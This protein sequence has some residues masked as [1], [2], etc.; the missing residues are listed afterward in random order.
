MPQ[1]TRSRGH[2]MTIPA[3]L[4]ALLNQ[5]KVLLFLGAGCSLEAPSRLPSAKT[6]AA[7][8][9]ADGHG[10]PGQELE[11]IAEAMYAST[12]GWQAFVNALP[13]HEWRVTPCN[14]AHAVISEL[15]K[16][17]LIAQIV[18]T[19]WDLLM[20]SSLRDH[21][22]AYAPI[23]TASSLGVEPANIPRVIKLHGDIDHPEKIRARRSELQAPEWAADWAAALFQTLVRTHSV[24]YIGYSGSSQ[25]VTLTV[26]K[27]VGSGE[28]DM[29]DYLVDVRSPSQLRSDAAAATFVGALRV[30]DARIVESQAGEFCRELRRAIYPLLLERPIRKSNALLVDLTRDTH[31]ILPELQNALNGIQ[32]SWKLAGPIDA[33]MWLL[34]SFGAFPELTVATPYVSIVANATTLASMWV[35]L[36]LVAWADPAESRVGLVIQT[37]APENLGG[38]I[39]W[40]VYPC[41]EGKRR[42]AVAYELSLKIRGHGRPAEARA[43]VMFGGFGPLP[44]VVRPF[45]A[46]RGEPNAS[47]A[48]NGEWLVY[49]MGADRLFNVIDQDAE[50]AAIKDSIGSVFTEGTEALSQ[51]YIVHNG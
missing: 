37:S 25:A 10:E 43:A 41:P 24:L 12:G 50:P 51:A 36:A 3:D 42:D 14:E 23:T 6:L 8:L 18:T 11:D 4:P 49:W 45:S 7:Q 21:G 38:T 33:Q 30:S 28:R 44:Q 5:A 26:A 1:F 35:W 46:A 9:I 31:L 13:K 16:E 40:L 2:G 17:G 48:R 19:N 29:P 39:E 32:D 34:A 20:E 27:I 47:V 15:V 22:I